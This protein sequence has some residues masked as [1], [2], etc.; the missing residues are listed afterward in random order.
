MTN[1][2]MIFVLMV[3]LLID[4]LSVGPTEG[5]DRIAFLLEFPCIHYG[6]DGSTLD[7]KLTEFLHSGAQRMLINLG[8]RGDIAEMTN[9]VVKV[10]IFAVMLYV[11][12]VMVPKSATRHLGGWA[13]LDFSCKSRINWKL[14]SCAIFLGLVGDQLGGLAGAIYV[15]T[16]SCVTGLTVGLPQLLV[17]GL[18]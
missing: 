8:V 15:T 17:G 13:K 5:R 16:V 9:A 2:T 18:S 4:Y 11:I 14:T 1:I 10:A 3:A 12:G 7:L 6:W